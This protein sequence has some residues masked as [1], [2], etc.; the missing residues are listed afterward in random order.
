VTE[1]QASL[2]GVRER[3]P[4][5]SQWWTPPRLAEALVDLVDALLRDGERRGYTVS[6][7]EPSAGRGNLVREVRRRSTRA[8]IT[9]V[10]ID[11]RYE[12][13]LHQAGA[14]RVVLGDYLE[15][16]SPRHRCHVAV[17]N[18]PFDGGVEGA[19]LAKMLDE[20]RRVVAVLPSRSLY[21]RARYDQLWRRFDPASPDR[22][23]YVRGETRCIA[24][25]R[26]ADGGGKDEISLVDLQRAPGPCDVRWL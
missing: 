17:A 21:G 8:R 16:P 24:R 6:A 19:H 18:P 15:Q 12:S 23:W 1:A 25:P 14:S 3:D 5:L 9:A 4:A 20:A 7:L 13:D 10:E 2:F 22:D 26:F 11:P